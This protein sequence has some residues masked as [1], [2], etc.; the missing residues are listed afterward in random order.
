MKKALIITI[1]I[2]IL[3]GAFFYFRSKNSSSNQDGSE[4]SGFKNFFNFGTRQSSEDEVPSGENVSEFTPEVVPSENENNANNSNETSGANT[5]VFGTSGPFTPLSSGGITSG[6]TIG[7]GGILDVGG[8]IGSGGTVGAGGGVGS[9]GGIGSG[10][11][12]GGS[13]GSSS[14]TQCTTDDTVIDFTPEEIALLQALEQRFY[15]LAPT[16]RTD[17]DLQAET[18]NY[19]SYKILNQKYT[20]LINYCENKAPLLPNNINRRV[21][22]PLYTDSSA[23]AYFSDGPEA[24]GLIN[25][26]SST[27]KLKEIEKFF[28]INIW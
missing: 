6:S 26:Q 5:S 24:D 25:M 3:G 27:P 28:R 4:K 1:I 2:I 14:G 16:L 7:S 12:T 17:Q 15:A 23:N 21:A 13:G 19:S 20:E 9:G 18:A 22:T 10:G 11:G 8:G